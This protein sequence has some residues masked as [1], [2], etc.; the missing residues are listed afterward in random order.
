VRPWVGPRAGLGPGSRKFQLQLI[1]LVAMLAASSY[2]ALA[3]SPRI[4][5]IRTS[6]T[7]TIASLPDDSPVKREF[8]RLHG[9]SNGL[10][11][12]AFAGALALF[13]IDSKE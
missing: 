7:T 9:L 8:G 5:A 11:A 3:I 12:L 2:S 10:L 1:I 4:D 6:T 13:W